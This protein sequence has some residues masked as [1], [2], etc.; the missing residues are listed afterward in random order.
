M[1]IFLIVKK[2]LTI[3]GLLRTTD[4]SQSSYRL[5]LLCISIIVQAYADLTTAWYFLFEAET[6]VEHAQT[7]PLMEGFIGMNILFY[8]ILWKRTALLKFMEKLQNIMDT[9]N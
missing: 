6:F 2:S 7:I 8:V 4:S 5:I 3:I 1:K 9:R